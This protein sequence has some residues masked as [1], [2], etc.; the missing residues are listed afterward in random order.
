VTGL[1]SPPQFLPVAVVAVVAIVGCSNTMT[2]T[3]PHWP[4]PKMQWSSSCPAA[5][6]SVAPHTPETT[7][8]GTHTPNQKTHPQRDMQQPRRHYLSV[9]TPQRNNIKSGQRIQLVLTLRPFPSL[10]TSRHDTQPPSP[11]NPLVFHTH[12]IFQFVDLGLEKCH[13]NRPRPCHLPQPYSKL[14]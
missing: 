1:A 13:R 6:I 9:K 4:A 7:H 12:I 5:T 8:G 11:N 10:L 14:K 2:T 3:T